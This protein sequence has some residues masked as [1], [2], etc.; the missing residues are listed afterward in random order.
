M[1]LNWVIFSA[2][3]RYHVPGADFR[4]FGKIPGLIA[5]DILDVDHIEVC[6]PKEVSYEINQHAVKEVRRLGIQEIS[7]PVISWKSHSDT[8]SRTVG[9]LSDE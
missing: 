8:F 1:H 3:G 2:I 6:H 4:L 5:L 9:L 7:V